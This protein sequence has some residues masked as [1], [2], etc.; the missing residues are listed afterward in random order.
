MDLRLAP[1]ISVEGL[2]GV[3]TAHELRPA[4]MLDLSSCGIRVERVFDPA[5]ASRTVQLEIELPGVD[6]VVWAGGRVTFARLS[7]LGGAHANGQPRLLCRAGIVLDAATTRD[8]RL[9]RDYV[10]ETRRARRRA[11]EA[12]R[13]AE[14]EALLAA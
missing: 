9:L 3:A 14:L 5:T 13:R 10:L 6:E 8:F 1:R 2:C 12:A 7:P 4:A 11:A